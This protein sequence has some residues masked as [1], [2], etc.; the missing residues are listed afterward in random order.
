MTD[1]RKLLLTRGIRG[2]ADGVV[3]VALAT[4]LT[5]LGF[6][7]FEVG[8]I[9]TGTLLGSAAVTLAV[10]LLGYRLSRRRILLG[11]AALMVADRD[12]VRRLTTFWPLMVVAVAGTLNPSAGDVSVFLPDRA[13]GA[14]PHRRPARRARWPSP[15]TTWSAR[16]PG[17]SGALAS[18][19]ARLAAARWG[20]VAAARRAGRV[21]ASTPLCAVVAAVV[22]RRLSPALEVHPG[23]ARAPRRWPSRAPS[24]CASRR[25]SASTR[26]AA[27]SSCS[28]C[29]SSGST[30]ASSSTS[31]T[32]AAR[33]LR[34]RHAERLLA[35][36]L[37]ARRRAHRP[38]PDDGLHA[39][40]R[41]PVPDPGGADADRAARIACLLLRMA[42]SQ[43]DV[44]ARQAFVMAVVPPEER[45]A[46][47]S[48]T[49]VPR[50]LAAGLAPLIAGRS[51]GEDEL[52][53]AAGHRRHAE[54]RLRPGAAR[55]I[56]RR[57]RTREDGVR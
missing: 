50:S 53:L 17:R 49:N 32:T 54:G 27:G 20:V 4:Y 16:W 23:Q 42:V 13:G 39:P 25:C 5:G 8:A 31:G 52:R 7:P 6:G 21:R 46:A 3:S 33:V 29:W 35:G 30:G 56:P 26:S 55:S 28:R 19:V 43:M 41:Q 2:L 34:R 22:Y 14:R 24:S 9:V 12:R 57:R 36:A 45:A 18:G 40:A 1:A 51:A 48:V 15:G 38:H 44:P 10:G 37:P 47:A 11:A